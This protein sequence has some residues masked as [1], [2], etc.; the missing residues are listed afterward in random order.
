MIDPKE[1]TVTTQAGTE[2]VYVVH[3]IPAVAAREIVTQYPISNIPKV[4]DYKLSEEML[5]K[6]MSYVE[7]VGPDGQHTALK[8]RAL[9]DNHVP[10]WET[11]MKLEKEMLEYNISF[12]AAWL[13]SDF[14]GTIS[15]KATGWITKTLIPLLAAL[16]P[17]DKPPSTN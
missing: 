17:T 11:L 16:S 10:D 8:T 14:F 6:L 9:V 13:N 7:A 5:L 15:Q 1:V 2:R 4:G 12:F 3:K